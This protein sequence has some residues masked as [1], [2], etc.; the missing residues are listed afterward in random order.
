M[1]KRY[2]KIVLRD[3]SCIDVIIE[4]SKWTL[5]GNVVFVLEEEKLK[6]TNK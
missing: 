4:I 2:R 6:K 3:F 1:E 5:N